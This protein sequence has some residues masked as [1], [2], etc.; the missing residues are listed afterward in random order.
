MGWLDGWMVGWLDGWMARRY[1]IFISLV[2]W[3]VQK[4]ETKI[5]DI[6]MGIQKQKP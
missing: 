5:L 3:R 1:Y 6:Y 2:F 4:I